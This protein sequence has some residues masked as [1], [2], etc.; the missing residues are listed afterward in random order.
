MLEGGVLVDEER[1]DYA[2][3]LCFRTSAAWMMPDIG[4][5]I[6]VEG[7][8]KN[9]EW[10]KNVRNE[11]REKVRIQA[12]TCRAHYSPCDAPKLYGW[13]FYTLACKLQ[14]PFPTSNGTSEFR[15]IAKE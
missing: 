3:N 12:P 13:R 10:L 14:M 9:S 4:G 7:L 15:R 1:Y 8:E 2:K 6:G 5:D 11:T